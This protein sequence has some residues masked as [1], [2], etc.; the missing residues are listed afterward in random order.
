MLDRLEALIAA[1]KATTDRVA[2][3]LRTPM[4]RLRVKLR[5]AAKAA[6]GP[7]RALI[8]DA[9]D[10][11][12]KLSSLYDALLDLSRIEARAGDGGGLAP[13]ELGALISEA[14][15]LYLPAAEAAGIAIDA[16]CDDEIILRGDRMLLLRLIIN[17][18]DNALKFSPPLSRVGLAARRD[19]ACFVLV[20]SD[21]G[22]GLDPAFAARAFEPF[23]R[24]Q[25]AAEKDGFGLGLAIAHAICRRHGFAIRLAANGGHGLRVEVDGASA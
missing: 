14:R 1:T 5:A 17:L 10:E 7:T 18:L 23:S 3:E 21:E 13:V 8:A 4:T 15:D 24:E 9:I 20:V 12:A 11:T 6:D 2:H 19:G 22:P 16:S 25:G